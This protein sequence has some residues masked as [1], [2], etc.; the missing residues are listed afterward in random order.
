MDAPAFI[1]LL[2]DAAD[3]KLRDVADDCHPIA[4]GSEHSLM[5]GIP[6]HV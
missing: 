5:Q 1:A 4:R 3:K 2:S 6:L